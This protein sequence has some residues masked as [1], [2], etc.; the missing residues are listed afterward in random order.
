[1]NIELGDSYFFI[2]R[3]LTVWLLVWCAF[4]EIPVIAWTA[5]ALCAAGLLLNL[6]DTIQPAPVDFGWM[7]ECQTIRSGTPANIPIQ[8]E[9]WI[10]QYPGRD[11][12]VEPTTG[13]YDPEQEG[14]RVWRWAAGAAELHVESHHLRPVKVILTLHSLQPEVI[15][16]TQDGTVIWHASI[17][18]QYRQFAIPLEVSGG[19]SADIVLTSDRQG[20]IEAPDAGT[21]TLSFEMSNWSVRDA[22]PAEGATR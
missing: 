9:G 3:I 19:G 18:Q 11:E 4:D 10:L 12:H 13:W 17:D 7:E 21:R 5:R 15:S 20:V 6:V 1:V 16:A 8:P 2:P 22:G 14:K